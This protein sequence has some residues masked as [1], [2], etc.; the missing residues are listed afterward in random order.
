[1][2]RPE[3]IHITHAE[4][5]LLAGFVDSVSFIGDRQ[6]VVVRDASHKLLTIDA[7]NTLSATAGERI[8]LS[9]AQEAIRL[10]PLV[11]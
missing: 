1:M 3:T 5:A 7:P 8:G 6:R 10:L 2:I 11:E 4:G 9:I